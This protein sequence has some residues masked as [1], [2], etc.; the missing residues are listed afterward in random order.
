M[1]KRIF[2]GVCLCV[3]LLAAA[4]AAW[5]QYVYWHPMQ[6]I[7]TVYSTNVRYPEIVYQH[8]KDIPPVLWEQMKEFNQEVGSFVLDAQL[9]YGD[10]LELNYK[11]EYD[12]NGTDVIFDGR[13][14][15]ADG[16]VIDLHQELHFDIV[17]RKDAK[18]N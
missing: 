4:G 9:T 12:K 11:L 17:I 3:A 2:I 6:G 13:G 18:W 14:T 8:Y 5:R 1:K 7:H 10:S 15:Q 16:T